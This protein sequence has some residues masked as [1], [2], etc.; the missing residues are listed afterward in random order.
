PMMGGC[1]VFG[2]RLDPLD[3][4]SKLAGERG[5]EEVL[6][7]VT[8]LDAKPIA[9]FRRDHANLTGGDPQCFSKFGAIVM[10]CL[11][12]LPDRQAAAQRVR[13]G[14]NAACLHGNSGESLAADT[15][16][17]LDWSVRKRGIDVP[18]VLLERGRDV[19]RF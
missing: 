19:T 15:G 5:N 13:S 4:A 17:Y 3:G 1:H 8:N 2:T 14:D 9:D 6:G 12:R 7:I 11:G 10:W 16:L 18:C